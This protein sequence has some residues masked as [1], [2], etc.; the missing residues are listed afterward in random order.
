MARKIGVLSGGFDP[1]HSGHIEMI[2]DAR[3]RCDVLLVGVNS[4]DWLTRKKGRF[5]MPFEERI[6]IVAAIAG[7][8][9]AFAIHDADGTAR[10]ALIYAK[11]A[12]PDDII[13]FMNGGDRTGSNIPEMDVKGVEFEFGVGGT[14][15]RNSSS[16]LLGNWTAPKVERPWGWYRVMHTEG[17][18][19]KVKELMCMPGQSLSMQRHKHRNEIWYVSSGRGRVALIDDYHDLNFQDIVHIPAN[20][21]HRLHN[22]Y[23]QPVKIIEIQHGTS[24]DEE[25][26]ERRD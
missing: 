26:I 6:H 21:W 3:S 25:D 9:H 11:A 12:Y 15:K 1:L 7:V 20:S 22:P 19:T 16:W 4:D 14:D 17:N 13:V 2:K 18:H 10:Y 8:D 23:E 24:C 5:F